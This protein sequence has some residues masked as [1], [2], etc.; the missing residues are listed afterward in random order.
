M[1][2][3]LVLASLPLI[4]LTGCSI[5]PG[6]PG[7]PMSWSSHSVDIYQMGDSPSAN[8]EIVS[9]VNGESCQREYKANPASE[10]DALK[11]LKTDAARFKANAIIEAQCFHLKPDADS[12]CY[13]EVSCVGRAIQW[14]D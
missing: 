6:N 13:S 4:T 8:Y 12:V 14:R 3:P 11:A 9:V 5:L 2:F 7:S 1:R 10:P